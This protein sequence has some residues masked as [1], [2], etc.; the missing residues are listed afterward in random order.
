M[1]S[2]PLDRVVLILLT[3]GFFSFSEANAN[4]LFD[5]ELVAIEEL[6]Y[7]LGE[8]SILT[9]VSESVEILGR[10]Y[11]PSLLDEKPYPL[12]FLLHGYHSSCADGDQYY[13]AWPCPSSSVPIPS[14]LG[15][16]YFARQLAGHGFI[17]VSLS[18]NGVNV[19]SRSELDGGAVARSELIRHHLSLWEQFANQGHPTVGDRFFGKVDFS[20]FGTWGHSRGGEGVVR[21]AADHK[22]SESPFSL[23]AVLAVAPVVFES[24]PVEDVPF[25]VTL[26]YCD[27]DVSSLAGVF[28]IDD[29]LYRADANRS[30]KYSFLFMGA[31]HNFFNTYWTPGYWTLGYFDG[32]TDDAVRLKDP[33]CTANGSKS[34]RWSPELQ[35]QIGADYWIAFFLRH[36]GDLVD[37]DAMLRGDSYPH[38][39]TAKVY[40][41]HFPPVDNRLEVHRLVGDSLSPN[42]LGGPAESNELDKYGF[43]AK[44]NGYCTYVRRLR[45]EPH[46]LVD[47]RG[48]TPLRLKWKSLTASYSNHVPLA[49]SDFSGYNALQLRAGV[50]FESTPP[51]GP[52]QDFSLTLRDTSGAIERVGIGSIY[53]ASA[54]SNPLYFPPGKYPRVLLNVVSVPLS[55]FTEVDLKRIDL[56]SLDFNK[57]IT[58][59]L[60][61][62]DLWLT[63]EDS[64]DA[65]T[66]S[67][68]TQVATSISTGS[69]DGH[70]IESSPGSGIGGKFVVQRNSQNGLR[71]GD[72]KDKQ[73]VSILSFSKPRLPERA[74]IE[75]VTIRIRS[76]AVNHLLIESHG[77]FKFDASNDGF[78]GSTLLQST[79]FEAVADATDI[80]TYELV[81]NEIV[82][83]LEDSLAKSLLEFSSP[84]LQIRMALG[85]HNDGDRRNDLMGFHAGE[86]KALE[87]RPTLY[88]YYTLPT[89]HD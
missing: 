55:N 11:H 34:G 27:G 59:E 21:H 4:G 52:Y 41:S 79:D 26:P 18:A 20:R 36:L 49:F 12:V 78:S 1:C 39:A 53:Q 13:I 85:R 35:Q 44:K 68:L 16:D 28:Y 33:Y 86:S 67:G 80:A 23:R 25:A 45:Q 73:V 2:L 61:V 56:V 64:S 48:R 74:Q 14:Y 42:S 29:G 72:E 40:V 50:N 15:Y 62:G 69:M 60:L 54:R 63:R 32:A 57:E 31:N 37:A 22:T 5:R 9:G 77:P 51:Q 82:V 24:T 6:T 83:T 81:D 43:C 3:V 7:D 66:A 71:V 8:A 58:G 10:V 46:A 47:G 89:E 87:L 76:D 84:Q 17:V 19:V 75:A 88:V 30:S 38:Q 70:V 65:E